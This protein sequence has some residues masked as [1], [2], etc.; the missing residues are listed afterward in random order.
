MLLGLNL[1][2]GVERYGMLYKRPV[3]AV[4]PQ[5]TSQDCSGCGTR[6]KKAL[7]VRTPVC[8]NSKCRRIIDTDEN[9]ALNILVKGLNQAGLALN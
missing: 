3:V 9:A 5:Y 2:A 7:S 8:L 4:P 1:L 6:V